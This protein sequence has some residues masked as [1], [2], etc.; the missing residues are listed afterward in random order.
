MNASTTK[1]CFDADL[2]GRKGYDG[3]TTYMRCFLQHTTAKPAKSLQN[4][5]TKGEPHGN[6]ETQIQ[7]TRRSSTTIP[8]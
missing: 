4:L 6:Q 2:L 3:L 1:D 5:T 7:S 8:R